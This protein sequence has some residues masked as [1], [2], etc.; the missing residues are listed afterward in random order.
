MK[1]ATKSLLSEPEFYH[2]GSNPTTETEVSTIIDLQYAPPI[3]ELC[4]SQQDFQPLLLPSQ[5]FEMDQT[6]DILEVK[7][8]FPRLPGTQPPSN[9]NAFAIEGSY[10]TKRIENEMV[11]RSELIGKMYSN[12]REFDDYFEKHV[13]K[14]FSPE[15][16]EIRLFHDDYNLFGLQVIYRDPWGTM[17]EKETYEGDLHL[18]KNICGN[19]SKTV[20]NL[21][22]DDYITEAYIDCQD[23]ITFMKLITNNGKVVQ[24]GSQIEG[25]SLPNLVLPSTRIMGFGGSYDLY[26]RSIYLYYI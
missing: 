24:V 11:L 4:L 2:Y 15:M 13:E 18:S 16:H 8:A 6:Q 22:Y 10:F 9:Y 17:L 26:L 3:I 7:K 19:F 5:C 12:H 20:L 21:E 23:R 14:F 25:K 1:Q